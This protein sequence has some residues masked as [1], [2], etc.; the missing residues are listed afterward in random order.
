[1]EDLLENW[2]KGS[3]LDL[4]E[5]E[6]IVAHNK[7]NPVKID[8]QLLRSNREKGELDWSFPATPE[9]WAILKE[10]DTIVADWRQSGQ[11]TFFDLIHSE[12][13][14]VSDV[15]KRYESVIMGAAAGNGKGDARR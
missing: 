13:E 10:A 11:E 12:C 5:T 6:F 14:Q 9:D 8:R 2:E 1:M 4:V 3:Y 15:W 7:H